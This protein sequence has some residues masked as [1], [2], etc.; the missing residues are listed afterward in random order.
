MTITP[1][2]LS[3]STASM[4]TTTASASSGVENQKNLLKTEQNS[5][6]SGGAKS[7]GLKRQDQKS[8]M[9]LMHFARKAESSSEEECCAPELGVPPARLQ[10][11]TFAPSERD[12]NFAEEE[13]ISFRDP[14]PPVVF[15]E[16]PDRR[17]ERSKTRGDEKS[18]RRP[19]YTQSDWI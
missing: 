11:F 10:A 17:R 18:N 12:R 5:K 4:T 7:K 13:R 1:V 8:R 14:L 3:S 19:P 9:S 16:H 2:T 6:K 15:P